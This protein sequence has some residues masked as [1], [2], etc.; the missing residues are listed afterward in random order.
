MTHRI[1]EIAAEHLKKTHFSPYM[2]CSGTFGK[3]PSIYLVSLIED[4][5][6]RI[7]GLQ[8]LAIQRVADHA[9]STVL[10]EEGFM[11]LN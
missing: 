7:C 4:G 10:V 1:P 6:K 11:I 5:E 8:E 9:L 3:V 2:E